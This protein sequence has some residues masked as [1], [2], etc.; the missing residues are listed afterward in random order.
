[1]R[2]DKYA[3]DEVTHPVRVVT[4]TVPVVGSAT[5]K[6]VSVKTAGDVPKGR[7]FDVHS[8]RMTGNRTGSQWRRHSRRCRWNRNRHSGNKGTPYVGTGKHPEA[9]HALSTF[10]SAARPRG[11]LPCLQYSRRRPSRDRRRCQAAQ[12]TRTG[13]SRQCPR[14]LSFTYAS[15]LLGRV[16][17]LRCICSLTSSLLHA[18]VPVRVGRQTPV[19]KVP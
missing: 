7:V 13:R 18:K 11:T 8:P 15:L 14:K 1:M 3:R 4:T 19:P 10:G 9:A 16:H 6:M 2:G 12:Q 17:Y 5:E